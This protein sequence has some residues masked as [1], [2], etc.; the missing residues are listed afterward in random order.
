MEYL[1]KNNKGTPLKKSVYFIYIGNMIRIKVQGKKYVVPNNLKELSIGKFQEI[2]NVKTESEYKKVI[3]YIS[4]LV[5]L[6][7]KIIRDIDIDDIKKL[8]NHFKFEINK[9]GPLVEA[10]KIDRI[11]KFDNELEN[12]TFGMFVDLTE[13]TKEPEE[14]INNIHLIM[15]ILYRP[16]KK[17]KLFRRELVIEPYDIDSVK[18]RAEYFKN[19]MMMDKII[20]ALFFF[21]NLKVKYIESIADYLEPMK[22]E[23]ETQKPMEVS[24]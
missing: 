19:N 15:A 9:D 21:I 20:G 2:N 5:G 13:M 16:I 6:D 17:R 11:Y 12:M 8:T 10:V 3:E 1:F 14:I 23:M 18:E 4:L 22:K 24:S 7:E